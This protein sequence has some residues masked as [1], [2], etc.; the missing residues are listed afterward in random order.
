MS[1]KLPQLK[2]ASVAQ[3]RDVRREGEFGIEDDAKNSDEGG[4]DNV[5]NSETRLEC[6]GCSI[7]CIELAFSSMLQYKIGPTSAHF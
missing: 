5:G 1:G 7:T 2:V 3:L 6:L 4:K